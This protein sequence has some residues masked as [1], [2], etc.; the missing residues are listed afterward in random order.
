VLNWGDPDIVQ[1]VIP[2]A[3]I[4]PT[5]LDQTNGVAVAPGD[6][7]NIRDY[8]NGDIVDLSGSANNFIKI[9]GGFNGSGLNA[10]QGFQAAI[11]AGAITVAGGTN[12]VTMSYYDSFHHQ[13]VLISVDPPP[14]VIAAGSAVDVIATIGMSQAQYNAFDNSHLQF[15]SS[16]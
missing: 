7:A 5:P 6:A 11:G 12:S 3:G 14:K 9:D 10:T 1:I 4:T 13:M 16:A 15:I 2:F 8:T